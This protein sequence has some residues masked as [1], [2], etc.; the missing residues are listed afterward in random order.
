M[1][2]SAAKAAALMIFLVALVSC[3]QAASAQADYQ[4]LRAV[5]GGRLAPQ[6]RFIYTT[7]QAVAFSFGGLSRREPLEMLLDYMQ[8]QGIRGTFFV[9]ERELQRNQDNVR[10]ICDYGQDLAIGLR[11]EEGGTYEGY[12]A[13]IE[14]I[15]SR[16]REEYGQESLLVRQMSGATDPLVQEA[17]SAMGCRLCGQGLNVVQSK[18]KEMQT[19][20]DVMKDIFGK[21]VTSLNRGEIVYIRTDFYVK[22]SLPMEMLAAIKERK[23]D[24][25]AYAGH[26]DA[27]GLNPGNDSAYRL[28]SVGDLLAHREYLYQPATIAELPEERR[29]GYGAGR[30]TPDNYESEFLKRYVGAPEVDLDGRTVGF[31]RQL[32]GKADKT[33]IV[34]TVADN[35]IFLTFDDWGM[36]ES[37]NKLLYVLRKHNVKGTFFIITW[38]MPNNPNLLRAIV[39]DG[40]EVGSHTDGHKPMCIEDKNGKFK[41]VL[42]DDEYAKDIALS[43]EKL[44]TV[45]GDVNLPSGRPALTRLLRPP[46]LAISR[47]GTWQIMDAG[48]SYIVNGYGS[49]EDYGSVSLQSLEGI[50]ESLAHEPDGKVRRGCILIMHMSATAQNTAKALDILLTQNEKLPEGHPSKF[51]VGLLGDY[52]TGGYAQNSKQ[53]EAIK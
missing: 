39:E 36:D 43:Y 10:L 37:I 13:Q 7:E 5:N 4:E 48:F 8:E 41:P 50:M 2:G 42:T 32:M 16:L 15:S 46:T 28:V 33:G 22:G 31:S 44:A 18:H 6:E 49:T 25:I 29:P 14:R 3:P 40:N 27:P 38:N 47:N 24:N 35:T 17:V 53:V 52:L 26:D 30:I 9:T 34:K 21:W 20:D 45:I 51:R 12:C 11:P 1:K 19:A 23:V